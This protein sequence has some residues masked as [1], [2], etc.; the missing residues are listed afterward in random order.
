MIDTMIHNIEYAFDIDENYENLRQFYY[1]FIEDLISSRGVEEFDNLKE[2]KGL[3]LIFD[4]A[5]ESVMAEL[6]ID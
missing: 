6:E 4:E 2:Y 5:L 1:N 3:S